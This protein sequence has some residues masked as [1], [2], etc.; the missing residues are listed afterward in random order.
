[1]PVAKPSLESLVRKLQ[2]HSSLTADQRDALLALPFVQRPLEARAQLF[3]GLD[4]AGHCCVLLDGYAARSKLLPDGRRQFVDV[5]M[6]GDLIGIERSLFRRGD[7]GVE[8]LTRGAAAMVAAA[9]LEAVLAAHPG[10]A[11]ALWSETLFQGAIQR[12]WTVNVGRRSG[13]SRMAHLLCELGVRHD[14][15]GIAHRE[16]FNLPL[17]Q[18]QLADC[19]GLTPVHVNR[20]LRLLDD[21]GVVLRNHRQV[22]ISDWTRLA[23]LAGFEDGYLK[24]EG[25]T[26]VS[27]QAC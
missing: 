13:L 5:L 21:Y 25:F 8:M 6:R 10:L 23:K 7:T 27:C 3:R 14:Q 20:M 4:P 24:P 1:M 16:K 18:E 12:E 17:T 9:D 15:Q 22:T 2:L 11:R 26:A 19:T